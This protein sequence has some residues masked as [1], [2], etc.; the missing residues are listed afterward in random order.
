MIILRKGGEQT[1][2]TEN[3]EVISRRGRTGTLSAMAANRLSRS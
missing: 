3:V 1:V 2:A